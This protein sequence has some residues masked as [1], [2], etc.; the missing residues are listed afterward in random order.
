M[1]ALDI[2]IH[3]D[4]VEPMEGTT[5][6]NNAISVDQVIQRKSLMSNLPEV[7]ITGQCGPP[8]R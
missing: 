8:Q 6:K 2:Y 5:D 4:S 7:V 3:G 1:G